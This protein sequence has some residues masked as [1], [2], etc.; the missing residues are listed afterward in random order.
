M[1]II[2]KNSVVLFIK[3][4]C[5]GILAKLLFKAYDKQNKDMDLNTAIV[6]KGLDISDVKRKENSIKEKYKCSLLMENDF[7]FNNE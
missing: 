6:E 4:L 5:N 2:T 1:P 3:S 7:N